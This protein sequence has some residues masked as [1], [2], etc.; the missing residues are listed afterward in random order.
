MN[1]KQQKTKIAIT[2][3][4]FLL[5][6]FPFSNFALAS[7][8]N[9]DNVIK[10]T[11]DARAKAGAAELA[12]NKTLD[13]IAKDKVN[14]MIAN[15]YFAHNSPAGLSPWSWYE[16]DGYDYK[17][18]GENL[19]INFLKAEDQQ[20]AWMNSP[21]HRKNILNP[22]YDEIGVAVEAG[23]INGQTAIITVQEFG[24]RAGAKVVPADGKNFSGGGNGNLVKDGMGITPQVLS[25]KTLT[26]ENLVNNQNLI[27]DRNYFQDFVDGWKNNKEMIAYWLLEL[28]VFLF[29][30]SLVLSAATFMAVAMNNILDY[31]ELRRKALATAAGIRGEKNV[32][33]SK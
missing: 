17:Y 5:V 11:N 21:D 31:E 6:F 25:V 10:L 28:A 33:A 16:K 26:G 7:E 2:A 15:N 3:I 8:I 27:S 12:E 18:A 30:A 32:L 4:V 19:A 14:D 1:K 29:S 24:S 20:E 9:M 22:N 23:R 13:K